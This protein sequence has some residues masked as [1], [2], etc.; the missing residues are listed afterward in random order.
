MDRG[1][2]GATVYWVAKS[3]TPLKRLNT[4]VRDAPDWRHEPRLC[5]A[6]EKKNTCCS[7]IPE[8]WVFTGEGMR[9]EWDEHLRCSICQ[10]N[11][12]GQSPYQRL[13][14]P[15]L[16]EFYP[17]WIKQSIAAYAFWVRKPPSSFRDGPLLSDT[18]LSLPHNMNIIMSGVNEN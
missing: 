6:G 18:W 5:Q 15:D 8:D 7:F 9:I 11:G 1:A 14:R 12:G 17:W 13:L 4:H 10:G 2:W 3:Q 16:L